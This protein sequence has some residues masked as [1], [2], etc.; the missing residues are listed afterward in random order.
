MPDFSDA[1]DD[2]NAACAVDFYR[3]DAIAY[4]PFG[5]S[6]ISM[7]GIQRDT[8]T[9]ESLSPGTVA[10]IW[11]NAADFEA[12]PAKGDL[13]SIGSS[14]YTVVDIREDAGGGVTLSLMKR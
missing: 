11:F 12:P 14:N 4:T 9:L 5:G 6:P 8:S 1:L 10:A 3:G 2:L 13:M 7:I